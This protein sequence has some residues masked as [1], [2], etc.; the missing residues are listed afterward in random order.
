[1]QVARFE[2]AFWENLHA[3][4]DAELRARLNGGTQLD[5][6]WRE[7]MDRD[8]KP[9][10]PERPIRAPTLGLRMQVGI[11]LRLFMVAIRH[12]LVAQERLPDGA[13]HQLNDEEVLRLMR[14]T[15]EHWD[16]V[17][18]PSV[19]RL[20]EIRPDYMA[21]WHT[22]K[23]IWIGGEG[24][25]ALSHIHDWLIETRAAFT[26]AFAGV[27]ET[28]ADLDASFEGDDDLPWPVERLRYHWSIP[29]IE[30]EDWPAGRLPAGK[31]RLSP[32]ELLALAR[33][34][35]LED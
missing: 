20:N 4:A 27:G 11:E 31:S 22:N 15:S 8:Y 28:V 13:R 32:D 14:N 2:T 16:Q 6:L 30:L 33:P 9:Y 10:S 3:E 23:E 19:S 18:G 5:Q 26:E 35:A 21:T 17:G 7:S 24:G 29:A 1:M 25:P 34:T 12:V